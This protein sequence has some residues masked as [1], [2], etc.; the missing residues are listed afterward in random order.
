MVVAVSLLAVGCD[1]KTPEQEVA[2]SQELAEKGK[3]KEAEIKLKNVIN[4]NA[5]SLYAR[6]VLGELYLE[7]GLVSAAEKEFRLTTEGRYKYDESLTNLLMS[8]L[9]QNEYQE[10]LDIIDRHPSVSSP[11]LPVYKAIALTSLNKLS[12]AKLVLEDAIDLQ[13]DPFY[14]SFNAAILEDINQKT[15][16]AIKQLSAITP[17]DDLKA[18]FYR[19]LGQ[20]QLKNQDYEEAVKSLRIYKEQLPNDNIASF[21]LADA[22]VRKGEFEEA[23]QLLDDLS[24]AA[25][26]NPYINRLKGVSAYNLQ[27][28]KSAQYSMEKVLDFRPDDYL[29]NTIAGASSYM[30]GEFEQA[31]PHLVS[32]NAINSG[33]EALTRMLTDVKVRLGYF[34]EA[35]STVSTLTDF[36]PE[37]RDL[38]LRL[39]IGLAENSEREKIENTLENLEP[40]VR[41]DGN[42]LARVGSLKLMLNDPEGLV[43]L[44]LANEIEQN[45]FTRAAL[46]QGYINRKEIDKATERANEWLKEAPTSPEA[47]KWA[48][49]LAILKSDE[50]SAKEYY[51]SLLNLEPYNLEAT[52][53]F[54]RELIKE[55]KNNEALALYQN[56]IDS[57]TAVDAGTLQKYYLLE[58]AHGA[59]ETA[60]AALKRLI[61]KNPKNS[62]TRLAYAYALMDIEQ[63]S[64]ARDVL[65]AIKVDA[66]VADAY[67]QL[68]A[69]TYLVEDKRQE[70]GTIYKRWRIEAPGNFKAWVYPIALDLKDENFSLAARNVE[71]AL[72]RFPD[73]LTLQLIKIQ[74][75]L[76]LKNLDDAELAFSRL[77]EEAS[78]QILYYKLKG[79]I[80]YANGDFENAEISLRKY[81][82]FSPD[83]VTALLISNSL[84]YE[85]K[86]SESLEFLEQHLAANPNDSTVKLRL[87]ARYSKVSP[88]RAITLYKELNEQLTDNYVVMNNL[89]WIYKD[90]ARYADAQA[91]AEKALNLKPNSTTILHTLA[92]IH[93]EK[94]ENLKAKQYLDMLLRQEPKNEQAIELL[95]NLQG[96]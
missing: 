87:A 22:L 52:N 32:A 67:W 94:G 66:S 9:Y 14:S 43:D 4:E 46:I 5:E 8:L 18:L 59:Q 48:A 45:D 36:I 62:S 49:R 13:T 57:A 83:T 55:N 41:E 86:E 37:D 1:P 34:D 3:L 47:V 92:T 89:A 65:E 6:F 69:E 91:L 56:L 30:L 25:P 78:N 72:Q 74:A 75:N 82:T 24:K 77:P 21:V 10:M 51:R 38:L 2:L 50:E 61:E 88:D 29:A 16:I 80:E 19:F 64:N 26:N 7:S 58:K 44:S 11:S 40:L 81:Y 90:I 73:N 17:P 12:E 54:T 15:P 53:F 76:M 71:K 93:K 35:Y 33:N 95:L 20:L 70:A 79:N 28:F 96:P 27:R 42:T 60:L 31:H 23:L 63:P 85:E 68:L 84:R 39:G